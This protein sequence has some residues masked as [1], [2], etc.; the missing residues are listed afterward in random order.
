MARHHK[1][2]EAIENPAP[3][4]EEPIAQIEEPE[5]AIEEPIAPETPAVT[6]EVT[7]A[8]AEVKGN[9]AAHYDSAYQDY[10]TSTN[11]KACADCGYEPRYNGDGVRVCPAAKADCATVATKAK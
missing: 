5:P 2:V 10:L 9:V 11:R 8:E 3:V 6:Q 1:I 4:V 7:M